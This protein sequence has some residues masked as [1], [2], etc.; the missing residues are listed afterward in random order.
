MLF[1]GAKWRHADLLRYA[2]RRSYG[3]EDEQQLSCDR[4]DNDTKIVGIPHLF[5]SLRFNGHFFQ[6]NLG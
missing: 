1:A 6:V 3:T 5:L 4:D 2:V